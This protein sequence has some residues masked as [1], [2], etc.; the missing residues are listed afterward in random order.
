MNLLVNYYN[1]ADAMVEFK[2]LNLITK[3]DNDSIPENILYHYRHKNLYKYIGD[4]IVSYYKKEDPE[5]QNIWATDCTRLVYAIREIVN[6]NTEWTIDKGGVKVGEYII[7]PI[8]K[9]M[10]KEIDKYL[11]ELEKNMDDEIV[12]IT[13]DNIYHA[14]K[15]K[16]DIKNG[17]LKEDIVKYISNYLYF[18]K[19]KHVKLLKIEDDE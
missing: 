16:N 2:K 1:S 17:K 6:K 19:K 7:D 12:G 15:L 3:G 14:P 5:K 8:L 18:D 4:I 11:D 13:L 9:Y 10:K